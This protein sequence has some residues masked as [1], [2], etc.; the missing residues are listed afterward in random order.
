MGE[1]L[2][3]KTKL[4][5]EPPRIFDLFASP[6][7][8]RIHGPDAKPKQCRRAGAYPLSVPAALSGPGVQAG[9]HRRRQCQSGTAA[10]LSRQ[11]A[12]GAMPGGNFLSGYAG[13]ARRRGGMQSSSAANRCR[14]AAR[15]G[16][17]STDEEY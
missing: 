14:K 9:G 6:A 2:K 1:D 5:Y 16:G 4:P 8:A 10:R 7:Y 15:R 12:S 3:S 13:R 17:S 11:C